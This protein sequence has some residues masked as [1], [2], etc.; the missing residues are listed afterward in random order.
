VRTAPYSRR[1][2]RHSESP[3]LTSRRISIMCASVC[4]P[5]SSGPRRKD[6]HHAM[7]HLRGR[8]P[9]LRRDAAEVIGYSTHIGTKTILSCTYGRLVRPI[10]KRRAL[11]TDVGAGHQWIFLTMRESCG[12]VGGS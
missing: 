1:C 2:T 3:P 7:D 4:K 6:P 12:G 5:E 9:G 11:G 8:A 10:W